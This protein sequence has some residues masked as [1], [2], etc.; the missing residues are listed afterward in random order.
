MR[1]QDV[2]V[3]LG[4]VRAGVAD[5]GRLPAALERAEDLAGRAG[6]DPDALRGAGR[7]ETAD[8]LEDLGH[9]VGLEREPEAEVGRPAPASAAWNRRAFSAKR[10][11]S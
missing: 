1:E 7:A 10:A 5:L 11:R 4:D 3:A 9:R 2:E 8:D 6:V